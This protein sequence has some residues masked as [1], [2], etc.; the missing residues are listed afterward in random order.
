MTRSISTDLLGANGSIVIK[1]AKLLLITKILL[2]RSII[3]PSRI[4]DIEI[5]YH[6]H[7]TGRNDKVVAKNH[8]AKNHTHG[9]C[10]CVLWFGAGHF[11]HI[12][13]GWLSPPGL[14][15]GN[16]EDYGQIFM[17]IHKELMIQPKQAWNIY[18]K[19][20]FLQNVNLSRCA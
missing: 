14:A 15:L 11:T 8:V 12:L 5:E 20:N 13:L 3:Y 10:K 16:V 18:Y 2:L 19:Q 9:S 1:N 17:L 7:M 6:R 4:T